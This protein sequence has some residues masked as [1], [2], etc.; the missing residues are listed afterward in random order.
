[1][2]ISKQKLFPMSTLMSLRML[3]VRQWK[4]VFAA[5]ATK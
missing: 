3:L 1:M 2:I 5:P 4:P